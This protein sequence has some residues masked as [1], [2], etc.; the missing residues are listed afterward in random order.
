[1]PEMPGRGMLNEPNLPEVEMKTGT[2]FQVM[3][4]AK[5]AVACASGAANSRQCAGGCDGAG[6]PGRSG[7]NL[8]R[9]AV[10]GCE[11]AHRGT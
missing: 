7:K 6:P 10:F 5:Q 8:G 9:L 4:P 1:M 3:E 2:S 11:D